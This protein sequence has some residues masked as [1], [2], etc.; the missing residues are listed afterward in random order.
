MSNINFLFNSC[1]YDYLFTE[2][3]CCIVSVNNI[4][5]LY[6]GNPTRFSDDYYCETWLHFLI[7]Y[8]GFC[9]EN[10]PG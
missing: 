6:V 5:T 7:G 9:V 8:L 1:K 4:T 3:G 2:D 10:T